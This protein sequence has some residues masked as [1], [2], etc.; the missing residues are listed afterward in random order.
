MA[1]DCLSRHLEDRILAL[2]AKRDE[3]PRWRFLRRRRLFERAAVLLVV[4][5]ATYSAEEAR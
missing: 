2:D 5:H 1:C 4:L 3:L